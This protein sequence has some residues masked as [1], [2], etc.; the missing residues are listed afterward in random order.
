MV[1]ATKTPESE[2]VDV[3]CARCGIEGAWRTK[4]VRGAWA[5]ESV[6]TDCFE[7]APKNKTEA[8]TGAEVIAWMKSLNEQGVC[9]PDHKHAVNCFRNHGCRCDKCE[10]VAGKVREDDRLRFKAW[11]AEKQR[12]EQAKAEQRKKATE[13]EQQ[14]IAAHRAFVEEHGTCPDDHEHG[15]TCAMKHRC[16]CGECESVRAAE[17]E[18]RN[19]K[20]AERRAANGRRH[21]AKFDTAEESRTAKRARDRG[22]EEQARAYVIANGACPEGHKHAVGCYTKHLCR[23]ES[24]TAAFV[25][26]RAHRSAGSAK[27]R[28]RAEARARKLAEA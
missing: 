24:C 1:Y 3:S 18:R 9:P 13:Q 20:Q 6:C 14:R 4:A 19:A 2:A 15:T 28:L 22:Y 8:L 12:K 17:R 5:G 26:G 10:Q 25:A 23:C 7:R 16:G 27:R 21:R 11:R